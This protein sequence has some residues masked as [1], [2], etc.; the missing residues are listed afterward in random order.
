MAPIGQLFRS[1]TYELRSPLPRI[2]FASGVSYAVFR[3]AWSEGVNRGPLWMASKPRGPSGHQWPGR[4]ATQDDP[5]R[6]T[7]FTPKMRMRVERR[8]MCII[9]AS[10]SVSHHTGDLSPRWGGGRTSHKIVALNGQS[11]LT[12]WSADRAAPR[13][14]RCNPRAL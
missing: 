14:K 12:G 7:P 4:R 1:F 9:L 5:A 2:C 13:H 10:P 6:L 8:D 3:P 11:R